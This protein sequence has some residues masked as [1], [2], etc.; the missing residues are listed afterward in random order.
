LDEL[1]VKPYQLVGKI[2][3]IICAAAQSQKFT[4]LSINFTTNGSKIVR[5]KFETELQPKF[6]LF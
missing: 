3:F 1:A 2:L 6:E 4:K 5:S